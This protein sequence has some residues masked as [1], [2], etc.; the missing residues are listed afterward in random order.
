[1]TQQSLIVAQFRPLARCSWGPSAGIAFRSRFGGL[2]AENQQSNQQ[3][4]SSHRQEG[5]QDPIQPITV[6]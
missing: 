5:K 6:R 1:L 2:E 4:N 3:G